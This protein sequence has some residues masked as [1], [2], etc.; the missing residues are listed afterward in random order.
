MSMWN[1]VESRE[2]EKGIRGLDD[3]SAISEAN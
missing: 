3:D 1:N 2:E